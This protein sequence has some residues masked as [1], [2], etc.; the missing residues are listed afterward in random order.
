MIIAVRI[1]EK[2]NAEWMRK[3]TGQARIILVNTLS[4]PHLATADALIDLL[5]TPHI[6]YTQY[7]L[8]AIV[9]VNAVIQTC[10]QLPPGFIR[11]NAWPGFLERTVT[12]LAA[13]SP[14]S[15]AA[16]ALTMQT[17]GWDYRFT[18]DVPGFITTTVIAM[19]I[20]EAWFALEEGV[21]TREAID[22]AMRLGTNYPYGPFEWCNNIGA[23]DILS[24]LHVLSATDIR[25]K[26]ASLL[27]KT[28]EIS[29]SGL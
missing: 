10:G 26:P 15:Q 29:R 3:G 1:N 20:N 2:Q 19:I 25:Y 12:E 18:P 14:A 24:L 8:P 6:D 16:A 13:A 27:I 28:A 7:S 23:A 4:D 11:I 22:T 5:F 17:L 21:S 9:M